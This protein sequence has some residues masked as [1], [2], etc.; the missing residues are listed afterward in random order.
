M[1][2][3]MYVPGLEDLKPYQEDARGMYLGKWDV[4]RQTVRMGEY[5]VKPEISSKSINVRYGYARDAAFLWWINR[6]IKL[7]YADLAASVFDTYMIW[8][9]LM[10]CSLRI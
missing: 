8:D 9:L 7:K 1:Q 2:L 5:R 6:G 4:G 3:T 10:E